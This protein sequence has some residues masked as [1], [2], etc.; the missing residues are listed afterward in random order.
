MR[1]SPFY[2]IPEKGGGKKRVWEI[3]CKTKNNFSFSSNHCQMNSK[4]N[5]TKTAA[6]FFKLRNKL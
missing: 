1:I 5:F 4:N 2:L 6:L 3:I